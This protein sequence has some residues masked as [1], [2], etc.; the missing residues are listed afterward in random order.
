MK[1]FSKVIQV[2]CLCSAFVL[3]SH[4]FAQS[5]QI[6]G[7]RDS[8]DVY[9]GVVYGPI[10]QS[11]TLWAISSQYRKNQQFTVY[12]V[13]LAIYE[14][15]PRAFTNRNFNTMVNGS[16]LQLPT[17][18]YIARI[19][20]QRALRKA[21]DDDRAFAQA[22]GRS[23]SSV[24]PVESDS[25]INL[26]PD[27]ELVN[28][29]EL[30]AA[31]ESFQQEISGLKRQQGQ[32]VRQLREQLSATIDATQSIVN[33][34]QL[35]LQKMAQKDEEMAALRAELAE[36]FNAELAEQAAEIEALKEFVRIAQ[37]KEKLAQNESVG[38]LIRQPLFIIIAT[39]VAGLLVFVLV[40]M[41]L[42]RK[43]KAKAEAVTEPLNDDLIELDD[44][45][46]QDAD[47]LLA[48]LDSDDV[49]D[50][51]LLDDILSDDLEDTID[52]IS[53]DIEDFDSLEDE[54]LVPDQKDDNKA[55]S[56][57]VD[58]AD[59]NTND[60]VDFD[61]DSLDADSLDGEISL[62]D[63]D[64]SLDDDEASDESELE[65]IDID[66]VLGDENVEIANTAEESEIDDLTGDKLD[67]DKSME[68][69]DKLSVSDIESSNDL[70]DE[71]IQDEV[72]IEDLLEQN[73]LDD[74]DT[75]DGIT[76]GRTGEIDESVIEQ[77]EASISDKNTEINALTEK[78]EDDLENNDFVDDNLDLDSL[79]EDVAQETATDSEQQKSTPSIDEIAKDVEAASADA[80][81]DTS[82]DAGSDTS[83]DIN[84]EVEVDSSDLD[85]SVLDE[86]G[87]DE[88]DLNETDLDES[89]LDEIDLNETD[90]DD[91][92]GDE[93]L[94]E[95]EAELPD[96]DDLAVEESAELEDSHSAADTSDDDPATADSVDTA[97]DTANT[98]DT[99]DLDLDS[100]LDDSLDDLIDNHIDEDDIQSGKD[101]LLDEI[102]EPERTS[103][104]KGASAQESDIVD[105]EIDTRLDEA[106][107]E[108]LDDIDLSELDAELNNSQDASSNVDDIDDSIL[109]LPDLDDWLD[110]EKAQEDEE[111]Q[112]SQS[113]ANDV[114]DDFDSSGESKLPSNYD[115]L[116]IDTLGE[117][118]PSTSAEDE[119]LKEIESADFDALLEEM[120]AIAD[121]DI[122][123][124]LAEIEPDMENL[125]SLVEAL[126]SDN[127]K[128]DKLDNPDLDLTAL[129]DDP[130]GEVDASAD[131][132]D[133][134][135][136]IE[137]SEQLAPA[138]DDE[139]ELNLDMS[140]DSFLNESNG[141][142]VDVDADQSSNLDLARVYIDMEDTEAAIEALDQVVK[143]GNAKQKEEASALLEQLK[144]K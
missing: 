76:I 60:D 33:E 114:D 18:R 67:N 139:I 70:A 137:E 115:D 24:A 53:P 113:R 40:A 91:P 13:M 111:S 50:D 14:L 79:E 1:W 10:D 21:Q 82:A 110:D 30:D 55:K 11:D 44:A 104:E 37:A 141:I 29:D 103:P 23:G 34:N 128:S 129:F 121:D 31:Q 35:V 52:E 66:Q 106:G 107:V 130:E 2:L 95:L 64:F 144:G 15:N 98:D 9:S 112:D 58:D 68:E 83:A 54:M 132:I 36:Q 74:G 59:A 6:Q 80:G 142:D 99:D 49:S 22:T 100:I 12:Q 126:D 61:V 118:A 135:N 71:E 134:D 96:K 39:T 122:G 4:S 140:L 16:M 133:V 8:A 72:N 97:D 109:D 65:E 47:D 27:A 38:T 5:T 116:A 84:D 28:K 19:D 3:S 124:K 20:P 123:S 56:T 32:V 48:I 88:I 90:L 87:L 41:V 69:S 92:L 131:F 119:V 86:S 125:D 127:G 108:T 93:L 63:D 136:L 26:K 62:D 17:E 138:S 42:L 73:A 143:K 57:K 89:G 75:P 7:P 85:E 77:I 51:D 94:S 43:P 81:S 117:D 25:E 102:L 45:A 105:L 78:L 120:G 46:S 101:A